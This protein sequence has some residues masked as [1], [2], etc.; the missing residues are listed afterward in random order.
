MAKY[1]KVVKNLL[2]LDGLAIIA[3][4]EILHKTEMLRMS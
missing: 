4:R 3:L 2:G 1:L